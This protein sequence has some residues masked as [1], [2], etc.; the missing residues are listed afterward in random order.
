MSIYPIVLF[1]V[2][3]L[4]RGVNKTNKKRVDATREV[5]SRITET[6]TGIQEVHGH[7]SYRIESN[8]FNK[9]IHILYKIRISWTIYKQ[10][11]K[12]TNNFFTQLSP[13]LIFLLGGYLAMSGQLEL[14]A[15]VAFLSAQERLYSPW[16]ELIA[17]Y[18]LYQDAT[19]R[20]KRTM[21]YFDTEPEFLLLPDDRPPYELGNDIEIKDLNFVTED[22]ISLLN[23][24]N[25]SMKPGEHLA[26]VG[27]SGSGKSTLAQCI[28]QLY[29]YSSG[30]VQ[31]GEKEVTDMTKLDLVRNVGI[32]SQ[33]PFIF[34]GTVEENLLYS[35]S[36]MSLGEETDK[37]PDL[38]EIITVLQQ[39]GVFVDVLRF[40]L[41]A[42]LTPGQ[43]PGIGG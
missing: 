40:G 36:A 34:N 6:L 37:K 14:G 13:F 18:D 38:D 1:L 29:K 39:T 4:Q 11:V 15:L 16:T 19:V 26:L 9:L 43:A 21:E 22:G 3:L 10:G 28:G 42:I 30:H 25:L 32:V 7:G 31:I 20:Y 24:I 23:N 2:P 27:F 17:M 41:N 33:Q 8:K 12:S 35:W 5:S